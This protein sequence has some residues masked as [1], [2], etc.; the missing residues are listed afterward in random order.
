MDGWMRWNSLPLRLAF[1]VYGENVKMLVEVGKKIQIFLLSNLGA[2]ENKWIFHYGE[3]E[4]SN[5]QA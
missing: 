1:L 4:S 2:V 3:M 5:L